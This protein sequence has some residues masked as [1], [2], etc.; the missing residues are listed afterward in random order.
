MRLACDQEPWIPGRCGDDPA[1]AIGANAVVFS[2]MNA[3]ILHPLHVATRSPFTDSSMETRRP[4]TSLIPT[5]PIYVIE[6]AFSRTWPRLTSIRR[7][8]YGTELFS[9]L[10]CGSQREL[11]HSLGVQP[12]LGRIYILPMSKGQTALLMLCLAIRIVTR[13]FRMTAA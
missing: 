12:Y 9:H 2:V 5:I 7:G 13:I 3:L 1:R 11:F 4:C 8:S 10:A 6:T